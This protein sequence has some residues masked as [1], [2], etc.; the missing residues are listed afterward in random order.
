[1]RRRIQKRYVVA[2]LSMMMAASAS[3]Q[4]PP[5]PAQTQPQAAG[6]PVPDPLRATSTYVLGPNDQI[7]IR[8]INVEEIN[9]KPFRID[10]DGQ[11]NLPLIGKIRAGGQSVQEFE[12]DLIARLKVYVLNPQVTITIVQFRTEPV[13][14]VGAFARPGIYPLLGRRTL[15]EMLASIGG[16]Q[17]NASRRIRL[18]RRRES[19]PIPLP[20]AIESEDGKVSVVEISMGS[21]SENVN[22]AED[23]VLAPYDIIKVERAEMI[24]INGEVGRIGTFELGERESISVLQALTMAGGLGKEAAPEKA[25]ILR[26]VLNTSRRAEIPLDVKKILAGEAS[27]FPLLPNDLL[28]IPRSRSSKW[29]LSRGLIFALPLIPTFILLAVR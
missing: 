11:I 14:F 13:F 7:L 12:A 8:S 9:D 22:P 20:N 3:A 21:L 27:D 1:M 26:P 25:R 29:Y 23:I 17:P 16:L 10:E 28:Y 18:T 6:Q 5:P 2:L 24:Y 19:G 15:V 4:Q